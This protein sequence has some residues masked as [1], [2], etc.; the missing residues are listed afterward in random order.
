M[1]TR[2]RLLWDGSHEATLATGNKIASQKKVGGTGAG[3]RSLRDEIR[4]GV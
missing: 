1:T 3:A 2:G 4:R